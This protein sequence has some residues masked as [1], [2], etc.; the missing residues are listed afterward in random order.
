MLCIFVK[1]WRNYKILVFHKNSKILNVHELISVLTLYPELYYKKEV[2]TMVIKVKLNTS[3]LK[4]DFTG[5]S[6]FFLTVAR[7]LACT[8]TL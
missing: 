2:P 8:S 4:H 5:A 1:M 3:P 6:V 7:V